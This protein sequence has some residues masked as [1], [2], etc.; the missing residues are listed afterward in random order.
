VFAAALGLTGTVLVAAAPPAHADLDPCPRGHAC[1]YLL[2]EERLLAHSGG[3]AWPFVRLPGDQ[4]GYIWNNGTR[5]P[6][7]DHLQ[8]TGVVP[9][10]TAWTICLHYGPKTNPHRFPPFGNAVQPTAAY[11]VPGQIITNWYWRGECA[12]LQDDGWYQVT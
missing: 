1:L 3:N 10:G 4:S 9:G 2:P 5:H 8:V 7:L 11:V 6:G 12:D